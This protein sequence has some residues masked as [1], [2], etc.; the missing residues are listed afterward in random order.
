MTECGEMERDGDGPAFF[1]TE[2]VS[3]APR[4]PERRQ[5]RGGQ[6]RPGPELGPNSSDA[7]DAARARAIAMAERRLEDGLDA[8]VAAVIRKAQAGDMA[9]GK[10][11]LDRLV[12]APRDRCIS[13]AL[14]PI[15]SVADA[16]EAQGDVLAAVAQGRITLAEAEGVMKLLRDFIDASAARDFERRLEAIEAVLPERP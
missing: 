6:A 16:I 5:R 13:F 3:A 9:A 1:T 11:I 10:I 2:D 7:P 14:R 12:P 8:V 4:A 15:G